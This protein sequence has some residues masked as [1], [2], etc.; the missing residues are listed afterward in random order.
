[1]SCSVQCGGVCCQRFPLSFTP[2]YTGEKY[3]EI[4]AFR[5]GGGELEPW[6][7][8][9]IMIAEM[10]IPLAE[11]GDESPTYTCRHLDAATGRCTTYETRPAMCRDYPGYDHGGECIHCGFRE[12][13]AGSEFKAAS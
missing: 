4:V 10:V 11:E 6:M 3:L 2:E 12:E 1:M 7:R 9:W 8:D 13:P 5:E